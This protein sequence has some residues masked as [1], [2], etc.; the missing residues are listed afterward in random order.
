MAGARNLLSKVYFVDGS[1]PKRQNIVPSGLFAYMREIGLSEPVLPFL[2]RRQTLAMTLV[3][4]PQLKL[5]L[6]G[7]SMFPTALKWTKPPR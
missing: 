6:E 3:G 5:H 1:S 7:K 2:D 4:F